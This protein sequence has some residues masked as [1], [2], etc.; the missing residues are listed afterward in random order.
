[1]AD[2]PGSATFQH[3]AIRPELDGLRA[4]AVV[5]VLLF[6]FDLLGADGGFAGVDMFFVLSGFLMTRALAATGR[7]DPAEIA[8]FYRRRFWRIAPAYYVTIALTLMI[9]AALMLPFDVERLGMSAIAAM[10]FS[11]NAFFSSGAGYFD[12]ASVYKPLLHT[13]SLGVE[14]QF[15]LFWPLVIGLV[16]LVRASR[17][18]VW[19]AAVV[20]VSLGLSQALAVLDPKAAFFSLPSR[21]WELGLGGLVAFAPAE[22]RDRISRAGSPLRAIALAVILATPWLVREDDVWPMPWAAPICLATACLVWLGGGRDGVTRLLSAP[23]LAYIGRLSYSLYLVHWP[24]IVFVEYLS[25]PRAPEMVRVIALAACVPMALLLHRFVETPWRRQ[26]RTD[27]GA[28]RWRALAALAA[29]NAGLIGAG[30]YL[31][32]APAA[33]TAFSFANEKP[34]LDSLPCNT[35]RARTDGPAFCWLGD[36][37]VP[38]RT[39]IW[40]DSHAV[41]LIPGIAALKRREGSVLLA[42]KGACPPVPGLSKVSNRIGTRDECRKINA[43]VLRDLLND[44]DVKTV[45]LAARWAFYAETTRFGAEKGSRAFLIANRGDELSVAESRARLMEGLLNVVR[46][47]QGAG[48]TV[49][50]V[51]QTPEMGFD[52]LRCV[53]MQREA[54]RP[55][56]VCDAPRPMIDKRQAFVIAVLDAMRDAGARIV[57]PREVLCDAA[58]CYGSREGQ[59]VY[60]DDNH[61]GALGSELLVRNIAEQAAF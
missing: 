3:P 28:W 61:L 39:A 50:I 32:R 27:A 30:Y 22:W 38:A 11:S 33:L 18:F 60:S 35:W 21:L 56:Q 34:A 8:R 45:V 36:A 5:A 41:H 55:L 51:G 48:K 13:W 44:A 2:A 1:M 29:L 20:L 47:L 16:L 14:A 43:G 53:A 24:V 57:D 58:L 12:A 6:H 59:I 23:P 31:H 52:A 26:G 54:G 46:S 4:L 42:S 7:L 37:N 17:R 15:Y 9:G 19:L 40:G 10:A 49:L 25:F